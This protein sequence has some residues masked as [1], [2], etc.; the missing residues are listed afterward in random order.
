MKFERERE[1]TTSLQVTTKRFCHEAGP[2]R[3]EKKEK[4][5]KENAREREREIRENGEPKEK[6]LNELKDARV[7]HG[8]CERD[9]Y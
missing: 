9:I 2:A 1:K 7:G 5:K 3:R 6:R 4:G 8:A